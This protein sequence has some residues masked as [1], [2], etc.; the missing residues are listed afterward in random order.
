MARRSRPGRVGPAP[1]EPGGAYGLA[2]D[3][4]EVY[5]LTR[6]RLVVLGRDLGAATAGRAVPALPGW[7]V[8]DAFAHLCG[9]CAD[10]LDGRMDG[11]GSP[12]WTARQVAERAGSELPEVVAEWAGRGPA[13][14]AWL[15]DRGDGGTMFVAYDVWNH[16]QDIRAAVRLAVERSDD[17]VAYLSGHALAAFD[18][19]FAEAGVPA[20]RVVASGCDQVLGEGD[21]VATVRL[22]DRYEV[23]RVLFG[24]R[25]V[26]QIRAAGWSGDPEPYLDHLSLFDQPVADLTE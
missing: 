12:A 1:G 3:T 10:V 19:R 22:A 13:L 16:E 4:A 18:R 25:S 7:T 2:V 24:R 8:K 26:A 9:L 11:A 23:L 20:L 14:D 15:R 5:E 21:P 6:S 17:R